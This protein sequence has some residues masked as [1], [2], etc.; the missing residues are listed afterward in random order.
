M[1]CGFLCLDL[2]K[3]Q[4]LLRANANINGGVLI[5]KIEPNSE[6]EALGIMKDDIVV[7]IENSEINTIDDF[8]SATSTQQKKRFYIFRRG[9]VFAVVL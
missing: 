5:S 9:N 2:Q 4:R 7:Q 1:Q 6:A 3:L 8:K